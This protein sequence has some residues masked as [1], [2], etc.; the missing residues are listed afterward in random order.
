[1]VLYFGSFILLLA[2]LIF[3]HE[4]G[5]YLFAKLF[6][7]RV[8]VFS[9][10]FGPKIFRKK[11]GETEYALSV[12]PLGGY[13][14]LLGQDPNEKIEPALLQRTLGAQLPWKRFLIYIGGPLF[15]FL[16]AIAVY[17]VLL[18]VG[19]PHAKSI[20]ERIPEKTAAYV[21]GFR[22]GDVVTAIG[23]QQIDKADDIARVVSE[24]MN[25]ELVF[26][27]K[28]A[29]AIREIKTVAA[30]MPGF[31][32]YGESIDVGTIDGLLSPARHPVV[33]ISDSKSEAAKAGFT[34][35]TEILEIG[36]VRVKSWEQ[37]ENEASKQITA[38]SK[39]F[40]IGYAPHESGYWSADRRPQAAK[41]ATAHIKFAAKPLSQLGL[42]SSELFVLST[43]KGSP[44]ETLGLAMGDRLVSI[45]GEI[46]R[47][48]V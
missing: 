9:M 43:V 36:G 5:H 35:G 7:V 23:S 26:R 15:N 12:V 22:T 4:L 19:E 41:S 13:V 3:I 2:P 30:P 24:S 44:A 40:D 8:D 47:A 29:G 17:C 42:R 33:G 14:K 31:S 16:M 32:P 45:D 25:R 6:G 39:E 1:M 46:G 37:L 18:V 38:G 10:G 27:V 34:T 28:R 21:A 48:H 11:V 20:L